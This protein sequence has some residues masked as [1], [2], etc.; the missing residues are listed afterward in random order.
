M[1]IF[2]TPG[3]TRMDIHL[4]RTEWPELQGAID[5]YATLK[6]E[7][8]A[9]HARKASLDSDR[10]KAEAAATRAVK[11][12]IREGKG[13]Q[14]AVAKLDRD[15]ERIDREIAACDRRVRAIDDALDD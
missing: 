4:P 7:L 12:A 6:R 1:P 10:L 3:G 13:E 5:A 9:T 15:L 2:E 14:D 8:R 11:D